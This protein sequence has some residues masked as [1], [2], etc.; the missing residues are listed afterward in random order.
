[1]RG[2]MASRARSQQLC[3]AKEHRSQF[4]LLASDGVFSPDALRVVVDRVGNN[5]GSETYEDG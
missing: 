3:T 1:M 2:A 4:V 5:F